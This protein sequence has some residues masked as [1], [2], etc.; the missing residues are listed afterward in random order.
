MK[1][2]IDRTKKIGMHP[3]ALVPVVEKK[4]EPVTI[5]VIDYDEHHAE[6]LTTSNPDDCFRFKD[7][8]STTWIN[9]DGVH[10]PS[11]IEKLGSHF[12]VHPLTMEDI[13]NIE[14]RLKIEDFNDYIYVALN[15]LCFDEESDETTG[16]HL[17]IIFNSNTVLTFQENP[18][19]V[20]NAVRDRIRADKTRIRKLGADFLAYA[21]VDAVTDNYF[22]VLEKV[23]DII[24]CLEDDLILKPDSETLNRMQSLKSEMLFIRRSVWPL[25]EI[26]SQWGRLDSELIQDTTRTYL[27]DAYD[28]IIQIMDVVE[29]YREMLAGMLDL[30]LSSVSYRMNEVMKVLTIIA[31]IFIPLTFIVGIYGMN[32]EHMPEIKWHWGYYLIWAVMLTVSITMLAWFRKKKWL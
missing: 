22:I 24:E 20:F 17:S 27:R 19:D 21:L 8:P 32:F 2:F 16:E 9:V 26:L 30:Y 13:L 6:E 18:G 25:R 15:M 4:A 11:I 23:G 14:G 1:T 3:G 28:H 7:T 5:T 10:D 12:N 29:V 31:T